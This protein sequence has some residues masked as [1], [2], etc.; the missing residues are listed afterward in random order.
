MAKGLAL[1]VGLRKVD[2]NQYNGW[3]GENGCWG[4][5]LDVDNVDRIL[6]TQG[7][8]TTVLKTA[9]AT[10]DNILQALRSAANSLTSE[11]IFVFYYSGHGGQQPDFG[12]P[13]K[14]EL[15]G[16]DETLVA[17]DREIIDDELNEI[18]LSVPQGARIVMI[19]DSCNSGTNYKMAGTFRTS[20]PIIPVIDKAVQ[21]QMKAQLIHYGG[22]RDG[23]SSSGYLG[24]GAFTTALCNAWGN[25]SFE[26]NYRQL[27]QKAAAFVTTGQIPQ[28]N[29]YGPVSEKFSNSRPF[30]VGTRARVNISLSLNGD[31]L[32]TVKEAL[33]K[34]LGKV[35]L[36]A[37]EESAN[38]RPCSVTGSGSASSG[39]GW[40]VSGSVTCTF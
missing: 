1:L 32:A 40:S 37:V 20:T 15:D 33:Q 16:Q 23:F 6:A 29:E 19:S 18:W 27:H 3:N 35:V 31:D 25:G 11:D 36:N 5:E 2:P 21:D 17:Y 8:Q 30:Q 26:G 14:D 10:H 13:N 9:Q 12:S 4:C 39:G 38:S 28:Y 22:C 34:E 7:F 24:G